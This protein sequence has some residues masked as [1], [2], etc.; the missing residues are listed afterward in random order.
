L[1]VSINGGAPIAGWWKIPIELLDGYPHDFG[2]PFGILNGGL[3][4]L[5][6]GLPCPTLDKLCAT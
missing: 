5:N 6:G 4:C 2:N 1:G 3:P